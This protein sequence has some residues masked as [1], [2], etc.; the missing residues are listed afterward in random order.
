M[1]QAILAQVVN[2]FL[3]ALILG[4]IC[5]RGSLTQWKM[6]SSSSV[7]RLHLS[8]A[9]NF[10]MAY[11]SKHLYAVALIISQRLANAKYFADS[12]SRGTK[13][14]NSLRPQETSFPSGVLFTRTVTFEA[15][16]ASQTGQPFIASLRFGGLGCL[17]HF[18]HFRPQQ[19]MA[20]ASDW[21][22]STWH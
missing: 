4:I 21:G 16:C 9:L 7:D 8:P 11:L 14:H 22:T 17:D 13:I 3:L 20:A 19:G 2:I 15:T 1:A 5:P 10:R 6:P 18:W 12:S